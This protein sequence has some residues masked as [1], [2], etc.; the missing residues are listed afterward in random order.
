MLPY[1][2]RRN[3]EAADDNCGRHRSQAAVLFTPFPSAK[4]EK[5]RIVH[6]LVD[7]L[8]RLSIHRRLHIRFTWISK[9]PL[10]GRVM[11]GGAASKYNSEK[12]GHTCMVFFATLA[13][14][15]RSPAK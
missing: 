3:R 9:F 8:Q 5:L 7:F 4:T 1:W 2:S 12:I 13:H 10:R 15:F 11:N 6:V 14:V